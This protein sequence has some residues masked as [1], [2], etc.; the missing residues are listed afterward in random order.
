MNKDCFC[1]GN[2]YIYRSKKPLVVVWCNDCS[3]K[4]ADKSKGAKVISPVFG[5]GTIESKDGK[6]MMVKFANG[7]FEMEEKE[8]QYVIDKKDYDR[9]IGGKKK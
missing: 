2:G 8:V 7:I 3:L 5:E 6:K 1:G 4:K 9:V